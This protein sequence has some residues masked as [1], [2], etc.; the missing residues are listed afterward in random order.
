MNRSVSFCSLSVARMLS[1]R[2]TF[3]SFSS[4]LSSSS[5]S[6]LTLRTAILASSTL[7]CTTLTSSF[8][9]SSVG[10][11]ITRRRTS[12]SLCGLRPRSDFWMAF[13]TFPTMLLSQ[14]WISRS[15]ASGTDMDASWLSGVLVP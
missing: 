11:G 8:R 7:L 6:R 12:P 4:F 1:S 3:L 10:G 15:L 5:A 14:G 9:R 13:C 2:E